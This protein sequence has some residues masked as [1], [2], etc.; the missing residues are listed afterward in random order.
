M[1]LCLLRTLVILLPLISG[2]PIYCISGAVFCLLFAQVL[3]IKIHPTVILVLI[4]KKS[5]I[6]YNTIISNSVPL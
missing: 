4:E 1:S 5:R 3:S 6:K 2:N